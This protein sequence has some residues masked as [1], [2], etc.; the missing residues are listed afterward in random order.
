MIEMSDAFSVFAHVWLAV[1]GTAAAALFVK[2]V[3]DYFR[4][5]I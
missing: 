2:Y 1:M 5:E 4:G 3:I